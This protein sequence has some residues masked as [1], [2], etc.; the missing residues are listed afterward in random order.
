MEWFK[1]ISPLIGVLIG[2]LLS[3]SGKLFLDIR[4]N[5]RKLRK[6]LFFLL[7]L[8]FYFTREHSIEL[9]INK[10]INLL[11]TRISEKLRITEYD[12]EL[13][14]GI[15]TW[16]PLI[17]KLVSNNH[18]QEEKY[19]YLAE[20]IDKMLIEMAEIYPI[21]AYELSGR[22][23]IK[24][25]LNNVENYINDLLSEVDKMPFDIKQWINPKLTKDLLEDL[26]ESIEKIGKQIGKA[27]L[28]K[29]KKKIEYMKFDDKPDEDM[30]DFIDDYLKKIVESFPDELKNLPLT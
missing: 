9:E 4:Q 15:D 1:I 30:V 28:K 11:K 26:D 13:S 16:K 23:N 17:V 21:L 27:T 10:Y 14:L 25:R 18:T 7:E 19:K 8:R 20:N 5:K 24:E 12:I 22:H 29:A 2:W 6:L 3:E